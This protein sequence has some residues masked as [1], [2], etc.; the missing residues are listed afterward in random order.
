MPIVNAKMTESKALR[1]VFSEYAR[2]F[3]MLLRMSSYSLAIKM[4]ENEKDIPKMAKRPLRD[5]GYHLNTGQSFAISRRIGEMI[6]QKQEDMWCHEPALGYGFT[7]GDREAF[8]KGLQYQLE[9]KTRLPGG[10]KD[11]DT[12]VKM[13]RTYPRF[14]P[15]KYVAILSAPLMKAG[16]EPDLVVLYVNPLQLNQLLGAIMYEWGETIQCELS[17]AAGCVNYIVPPM[18]H[19]NFWVSV[20]CHGDIA[21]AMG[22]KDELVF[23]APFDKVGALISAVCRRAE[24]GRGIPMHY[25]FEPEGWLPQT[26]IDIAKKMKMAGAPRLEKME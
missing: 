13:G 10:A 6:A 23:S 8:D 19:N 15:D 22:H 26:Y 5:F 12:A 11:I 3:E 25:H 17:A 16:F 21:F 24:G 9:G 18:L 4:V 14:E 1:P 7:G 20:P 2:N